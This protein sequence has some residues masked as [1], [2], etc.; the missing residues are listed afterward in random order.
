MEKI[1]ILIGFFNITQKSN[2][3]QTFNIDYALIQLISKVVYF[4]N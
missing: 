2:I 3:T 1:R 4:S